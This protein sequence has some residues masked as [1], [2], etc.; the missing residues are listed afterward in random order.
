MS[1]YITL[2]T[3]P[4][5]HPLRNT[6]LIEIDAEFKGHFA[7]EYRKVEPGHGFASQTYNDLGGKWAT[8][9]VTWRVPQSAAP[10]TRNT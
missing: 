9:L 1:D 3:L 7:Y 6:L 10:S 2:N 8:A 5:E 4:E